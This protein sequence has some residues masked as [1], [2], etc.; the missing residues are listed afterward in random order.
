MIF[1]G[2]FGNFLAF[3]NHVDK[4]LTKVKISDYINKL[5]AKKYAQTFF[6]K[7]VT[8]KRTDVTKFLIIMKVKLL[9]TMT[10]LVVVEMQIP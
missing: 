3:V 7:K 4:Q 6:S 2:F 10:K 1:L 8:I 9:Y 5:L